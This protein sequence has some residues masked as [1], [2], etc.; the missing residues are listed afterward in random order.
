MDEFS[1]TIN[2]GQTWVNIN[3]PDCSKFP[4]MGVNFFNIYFND[5]ICSLLLTYEKT[6]YSIFWREKLL[7]RLHA[8]KLLLGN[9]W[10]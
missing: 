6:N 8:V 2:S 10:E 3:Q 5:Q 9:I 1:F 4:R 7:R